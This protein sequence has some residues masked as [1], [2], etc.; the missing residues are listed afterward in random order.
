MRKSI[1]DI[2]SENISIESEI[3]RII[4]MATKENVLA[5]NT[6]SYYT[7][8]EF[9][10]E[11]CFKEWERRGHFIDLDDFLEAVGFED[12]IEDAKYSVDD[13]F[14]FIEVVY[15]FWQLSCE[16]LYSEDEMASK[17]NWCGNY[18]HLKEVMDDILQQYNHAVHIDC[19]KQIVLVIENNP[20]ATAVA[21]L[22]TKDELS[23]DILKYNHRSL[24][25]DIELKKS[26]LLSLAAEIEPKRKLLHNINAKLE[27]DIFFMLNNLNIRHNNRSKKD[28]NYKEYV[29]KMK[30]ASLEKWYDELYQMLLLAFLQLDNIKRSERVKEL[31]LKCC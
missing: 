1:F 27:D 12:L 15:N 26:I 24:K 30:K 10:D 29:A 16:M 7:L 8:F 5:V 31:K 4:K 14:T 17:V 20:E 22:M 2:V 3:D 9:V 13:L 23:L 19:D 21:E 11:Y 18:Y 25:G 28:K 6:Y